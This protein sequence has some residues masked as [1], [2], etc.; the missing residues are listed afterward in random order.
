M[1]LG[2]KA[3]GCGLYWVSLL[4]MVGIRV[5]YRILCIQDFCT[6]LNDRNL[7]EFQPN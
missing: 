6:K 1:A 4:G 2:S 5:K 7:L 3:P